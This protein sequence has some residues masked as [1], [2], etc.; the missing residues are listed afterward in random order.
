MD[1]DEN[2][3]NTGR[4]VEFYA[5]TEQLA[6][7]LYSEL[8]TEV[9]QVL[10][11]PRGSSVRPLH[12]LLKSELFKTLS[13]NFS[14]QGLSIHRAAMLLQRLMNLASSGSMLM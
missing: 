13:V 8:P 4:R 10:A 11:R 6:V 14:I 1:V 3:A 7:T 2:F 9:K 5:K 12:A